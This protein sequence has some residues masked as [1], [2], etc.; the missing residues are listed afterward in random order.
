MKELKT[1][2]MNKLLRRGVKEAK[3]CTKLPKTGYIIPLFT[4]EL[5][6]GWYYQVDLERCYYDKPPV[7]TVYAFK[8]P[9]VYF[10]KSAEYYLC[11]EFN[12]KD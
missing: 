1:K 3:A 9:R 10:A 7:V 12:K 6:N 11:T 2:M 5:K 8:P 4:C